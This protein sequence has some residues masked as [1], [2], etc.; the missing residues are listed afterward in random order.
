MAVDW[1]AV[2]GAAAA[3]GL[4][5]NVI[6]GVWYGALFGRRFKA[7]FE[8]NPDAKPPERKPQAT[9]GFAF[10]WVFVAGVA[11]A[12]AYDAVGL[13]LPPPTAWLA[14][15]ELGSFFFLGQLL[16]ALL[17]P[18]FV[19]TFPFW[20]K[21]DLATWGLTWIVCGAVGGVAFESLL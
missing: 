15:A 16:P 4:V 12:L 8:A 6:A 10:L 20:A 21:H 5:G 11:F 7:W 1:V 18:Y 13:A 9:Y 3:F 17:A 14:G 2:L 19:R